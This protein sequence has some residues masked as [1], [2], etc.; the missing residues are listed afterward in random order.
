MRRGVP[1][2]QGH[3]LECR[4]VL[5]AA[6]PHR[7]PRRGARRDPAGERARRAAADRRARRRGEDGGGDLHRRL[8]PRRHPAR[9][10]VPDAHRHT[11]NMQNWTNAGDKASVTVAPRDERD[12][13]PLEPDERRLA[14]RV[15][16]DDLHTAQVDCYYDS[17]G[18]TF[19]PTHRA[20]LRPRLL[21]LAAE[22]L[23]DRRFRRCASARM[24]VTGGTCPDPYFVYRPTGRAP[25]AS[26]RRSISAPIAVGN[27]AI[28]RLGADLRRA[29]ART[30]LDPIMTAG[31]GHDR[32]AAGRF[33]RSRPT[34]A[35]SRFA[36]RRGARERPGPHRHQ[37]RRRARTAAAT[38]A[39]GPSTADSRPADVSGNDDISGP[40]RSVT[41]WNG[42]TSG[43]D[44][45]WQTCNVAA[46]PWANSFVSGSTAPA[47]HRRPG[48][49]RGLDERLAT[50]SSRC[51]S[52]RTRAP[53]G[54]ATRR[55]SIASRA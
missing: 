29:S 23:R 32:V 9:R 34:P 10:R 26:A 48:R 45:S 20:R 40:I 44:C 4:L 30:T 49:G 15:D 7:H 14:R 50:A 31:H 18:A 53:A 52:R 21:R 8:E 43:S 1:R 41:I 46:G 22:L 38:L 12:H 6:L 47:L 24:V 3:R 36:L 51:A 55:R 37:R 33:D 11:A 19:T 39:S 54:Q 5:R 27:I 13:P 25:R 35:R 16:H 2:R 42:D 17:G 28:T